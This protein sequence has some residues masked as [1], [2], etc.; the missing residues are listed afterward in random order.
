MRSLT[1]YIQPDLFHMV[2]LP[3][4]RP[5]QTLC[6]RISMNT[7]DMIIPVTLLEKRSV[8]VIGADASSI[9]EK[10]RQ[11]PR[12]RFM[13]EKQALSILSQVSNARVVIW[14]KKG[15]NRETRNKLEEVIKNL[16]GPDNWKV[17]EFSIHH[18]G[19][20]EPILECLLAGKPY[21]PDKPCASPEPEDK[22]QPVKEAL[23]NE[24]K[25]SQQTQ[26]G[27]TAPKPGLR[28]E[29]FAGVVEMDVLIVPSAPEQSDSSKNRLADRMREVEKKIEILLE[30]VRKLRK[31]CE[32]EDQR[33]ITPMAMAAKG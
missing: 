21:Q 11:N 5:W 31:E 27:D 22:P 17:R 4:D 19:E 10:T 16:R 7:E 20:Y 9:E 8:V 2:L 24:K 15:L 13:S 14:C 25:V 28:R 12:L 23:T 26:S 3:S 18:D 29:V 1:N 6:G 32:Q 30:E 33:A